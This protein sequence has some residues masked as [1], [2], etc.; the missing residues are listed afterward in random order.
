MSKDNIFVLLEAKEH[1]ISDDTKKTKF[2]FLFSC[3]VTVSF[4]FLHKSELQSLFGLIRFTKDTS[5]PVLS[6]V[7]PAFLVSI[8]QYLLYFHYYN[9]SLN[10]WNNKKNNERK[11]ENGDHKKSNYDVAFYSF[12]EVIDE[13]NQYSNRLCAFEFV[14]PSKKYES[15]LSELAQAFSEVKTFSQGV[16]TKLF[17]K[18]TEFEPYHNKWNPYD[19]TN[20]TS[21]CE[22]IV[23]RYELIL[24]ELASPTDY[25]MTPEY[26]TDLKNDIKEL[27]G[28]VSKFDAEL[29]LI[30]Q[31]Q[32]ITSHYN[33]IVEVVRK[34]NSDF[35]TQLDNF[36]IEQE[37]R[38]RIL[39]EDIK[40]ITN[41][42]HD[43]ISSI[44]EKC[45]NEKRNKLIFN[46]IPNIVFL[47]TICI[48]VYTIFLGDNYSIVV[49]TYKEWLSL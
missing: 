49:N 41:K 20:F 2:I 8:Y 47:L 12:N 42:R 36:I 48:S 26:L 31:A 11:D 29:K 4:C 18:Q 22:H 30:Y 21:K 43:A 27:G 10:S 44:K 45:V 37:A 6:L 9:E 33:K 23:N 28:L 25:K 38:E 40:E 14:P 34:I 15:D 7:I 13:F 39:K 16:E 3:L 32:C 1:M 19:I 17:P 46:Y 5:I 24:R 35:Y